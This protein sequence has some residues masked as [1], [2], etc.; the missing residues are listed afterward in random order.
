[1]RLLTVPL[2]TVLLRLIDIRDAIDG[3][4]AVTAGA[5]Y[6]AFDTTWGM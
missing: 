3:I 5:T 6:E 1:M 4:A 2:R